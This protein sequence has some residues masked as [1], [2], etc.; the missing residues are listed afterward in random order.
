[1]IA[2][3][4]HMSITIQQDGAKAHFVVKN[5]VCMDAAW[6]ETLQEYRL[7]DKINVITHSANS[8]DLNVHDLGFFNL[9]T[10][11]LLERKSKECNAAHR[12]G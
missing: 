5:D 3:S 2:L 10:I 12:H 9:P 4:E 1:M 6:N 8:P 11:I 7:Q